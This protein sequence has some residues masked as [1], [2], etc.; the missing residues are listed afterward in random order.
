MQLEFNVTYFIIFSLISFLTTFFIAK[1]LKIFFSNSLLDD[2][3]SKPQAFHKKP[4]ARAGGIAIFILFT[5]FILFYFFS[6][7]ILLKDYFIISLFL[8]FLGF[9][10]D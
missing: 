9:L 10:D 1:Y 5:L 6:T 4:V 7:D 8:F 2:D 3:F